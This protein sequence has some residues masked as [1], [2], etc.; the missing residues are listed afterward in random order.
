MYY[1][2]IVRLLNKKRYDEAAN[3]AEI[4]YKCVREEQV[5]EGFNN[6]VLQIEAKRYYNYLCFASK[7]A[8]DDA[9]KEWR[10]DRE[11]EKRFIDKLR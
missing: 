5:E 4:C 3:L 1:H 8:L 6:P 9:L 7:K 10:A 2:F 11:K